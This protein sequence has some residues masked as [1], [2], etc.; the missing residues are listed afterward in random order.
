[1]PQLR[2]FTETMAPIYKRMFVDPE[3][4]RIPW[5]AHLW[6]TYGDGPL[7]LKGIQRLRRDIR[8]INHLRLNHRQMFPSQTHRIKDLMR[9]RVQLQSRQIYKTIFYCDIT[10][11]KNNLLSLYPFLELRIPS[12]KGYK[13]SF[14]D[15]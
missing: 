4:P 11:V 7:T 6:N 3:N 1:M 9:P 14:P 15:F 2:N 12:M 13:L 8:M 5:K 10:N